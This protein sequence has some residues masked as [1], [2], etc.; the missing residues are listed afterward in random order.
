[1]TV[2]IRP[3][4]PAHRSAWDPLW[5]AYLVF[6]E[7]DLDPAITTLTWQ[8]LLDPAEPM[9]GLGAWRGD[10]LVGFCH[11]LFHR[12]TWSAGSH[13]YLEDLFTR[14]EA[15]GTGVGRA[16]IE[17]TA[18]VATDAGCDKLHWQTQQDNATAQALYRQVATDRGALVFERD[19][20]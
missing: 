12:S 17:A 5:A 16:L 18:R 11:H 6:Y 15:R 7:E 20:P 3:F 14:P 1:M 13:C 10:D 4:E 8:R 19:L 2:E 9:G